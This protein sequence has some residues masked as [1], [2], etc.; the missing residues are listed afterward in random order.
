MTRRGF[1]WNPEYQAG[2]GPCGTDGEMEGEGDRP[3][4]TAGHPGGTDHGQVGEQTVLSRRNVFTF[5][6]SKDYSGNFMWIRA[7]FGGVRG[8]KD[9][10]NVETCRNARIKLETIWKDKNS[11]NYQIWE[12]NAG[13][14]GT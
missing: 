2:W 10:E 8:G 13:A 14:E 11:R 6:F 3:W 12:G 1:A 4:Q 9:F 7:R 5:F